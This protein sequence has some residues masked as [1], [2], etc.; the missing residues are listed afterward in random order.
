M[1]ISKIGQETWRNSVGDVY[2]LEVWASLYVR[3]HVSALRHCLLL[4]VCMC[5]QRVLC[6]ENTDPM[7]VLNVASSDGLND[8]VDCSRLCLFLVGLLSLLNFS[9]SDSFNVVESLL[10]GSGVDIEGINH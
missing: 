3:A 4:C 2:A 9:E 6:H 8:F 5:A 10:I 7:V 1:R